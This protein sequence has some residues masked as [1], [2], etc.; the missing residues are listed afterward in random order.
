MIHPIPDLKF[1]DFS[2]IR[3]FT[4]LMNKWLWEKIWEVSGFIY[5]LFFL[6]INYSHTQTFQNV[7]A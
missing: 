7:T 2:I 5:F 1:H 6:N 3:W 4:N